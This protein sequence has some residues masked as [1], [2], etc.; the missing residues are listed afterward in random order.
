MEA[1]MGM[2]IK[3]PEVQ[4]LAKQLAQA[5]GQS[6][7][8]AIEGALREKLYRVHRERDIE[9]RRAEVRRIV[10]RNGPTPSGMTSDHSDLYDEI[11][12]PK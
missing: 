1:D 12:L 7:T 9:L 4:R 6:M 11:G 5:T 8:M 10:E 3:N 2:N